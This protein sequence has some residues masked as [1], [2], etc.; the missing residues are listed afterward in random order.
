M[1]SEQENAEETEAGKAQTQ[2]NV[3]VISVA[4]TVNRSEIANR[5]IFLPPGSVLS[6]SSC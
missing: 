3:L 2:L 1:N 6:V 5:K 4:K